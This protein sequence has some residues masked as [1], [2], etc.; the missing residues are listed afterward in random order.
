MKKHIGDICYVVNP[1]SSA[2]GY[3]YRFADLG[4][5]GKPNYSWVLIKDSD[6]T[7]ALQD[8]IDINGEITGIKQFDTE[9]S[10][11]KTNTD[12]ELSSLKTKT[13]SLE[14]DIGTKVSSSSFN[15]LK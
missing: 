11:W 3:C 9:I 6:V 2:D 10:S 7:K 15:E 8:I 12:A 13:T 4:T 1:T 14:T 5:N